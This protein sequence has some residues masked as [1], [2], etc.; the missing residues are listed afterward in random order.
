MDSAA[1]PRIILK[2]GVSWRRPSR[3]GGIM[4]YRDTRL[5]AAIVRGHE[6]LVVEMLVDDGR[7]FWLLAGG[8]HE[9]SDVDES[10][11]IAREVREE[12]TAA[13]SVERLLIEA[14]AHPDDATYRRYRT[15]L[16][17]PI[18]GSTSTTRRR[19]DVTSRRTVFFIRSSGPSAP[20][21]LRRPKQRRSR[22]ATAAELAALAFREIARDPIRA[23]SATKA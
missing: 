22:R 15:F 13:V 1:T 18:A 11:A 12:T 16:C 9:R 7:R 19:G 3:G 2:A 17:Q 5:Q 20:R 21:S 8:G 6:I 4:T 23:L 14:P 10:A